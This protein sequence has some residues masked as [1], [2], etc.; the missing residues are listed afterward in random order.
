M[1]ACG[2]SLC[3]HAFS[4]SEEDLAA[5]LDTLIGMPEG[6][7]QDPES[8]SHRHGYGLFI[9]QNGAAFGHAGRWS[10][11]RSNVLYFVESGLTIAVQTNR[12][13]CLDLDGLI[14]RIR[15][16]VRASG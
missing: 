10:G 11:F 4:L 13:G 7:W 9:H 1:L 2:L 12:D 6:E 15:D 16:R 3:N 5:P 14:I 8:P